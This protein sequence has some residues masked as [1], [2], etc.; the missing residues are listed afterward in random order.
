M[1]DVLSQSEIDNLLK[2]LTQGDFSDDEESSEVKVKK[3]DFRTANKFTKEQVRTLHNVYSNFTHLLSTYLSG[4][5]RTS[6]QVEVLSAE[7]QTYSE[8]TNSLQSP[9]ILAIVDMPPLDGSTLIEVSPSIAYGILN[10]LLGGKG[11]DL[12]TSKTFTDIDIALIERV[13]NQILKQIDSAWSRI[14]QVKSKLNRIETSPQFAQIVSY[15]EP[16][17]IITISVKIGDEVDG[18]INVCIPYVAIDPINTNMESSMWVSNKI[19]VDAENEV[20]IRERLK[21]ARFDITANFNR[22]PI[23]LQEVLSLDVGDVLK[24]DHRVNEGLQIEIAG[25]PKFRGKLGVFENKYAIK[26]AEKIEED[27]EDE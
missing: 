10:R 19:K 23:S 22:M 24:L 21:S 12:E 18:F 1:S 9:L 14:V 8:Y 15:S 16:T 25:M 6:C 5:L 20:N 27:S 26:L 7:E 2:S 4:T 11:G 17:V 3:Y 13:L